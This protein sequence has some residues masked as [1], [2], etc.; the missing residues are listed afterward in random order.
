MFPGCKIRLRWRAQNGNKNLYRGSRVVR[1]SG[2]IG[3]A[4]PRRGIV[5]TRRCEARRSILRSGGSSWSWNTI[6]FFHR[7]TLTENE[8]VISLLCLILRWI[9][10]VSGNWMSISWLLRRFWRFFLMFHN[11]RLAYVHSPIDVMTRIVFLLL[12][13]HYSSSFCFHLIPTT[14]NAIIRKKNWN[15]CQPLKWNPLYLPGK[16]VC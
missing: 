5:G 3:L 11:L 7:P 4:R 14:S 12:E 6:F 9:A 10:G 16:P 2:L 1:S 8:A 13:T 15:F